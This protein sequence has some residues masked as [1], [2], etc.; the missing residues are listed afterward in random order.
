MLKIPFDVVELVSKDNLGI[1]LKF[2][3]DGKIGSWRAG[4]PVL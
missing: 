1:S 3:V 4:T 2:C